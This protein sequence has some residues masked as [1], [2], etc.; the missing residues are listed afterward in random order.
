[1]DESQ[2]P[3]A[4][5]VSYA[6]PPIPDGDRYPVRM[7]ATGGGRRAWAIAAVSAVVVLLVGV[8]VAIGVLR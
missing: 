2:P 8:V 4:Q 7:P 5:R 3:P 6:Q 1:M